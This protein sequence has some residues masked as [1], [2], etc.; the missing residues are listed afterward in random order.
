MSI[1][2][3]L[4]KVQHDGP[5][6]W[7][8]VFTKL[9]IGSIISYMGNSIIA[10]V[11]SLY[12]FDKTDSVLMFALYNFL[13]NGVKVLVPP[14][15]GPYLDRFSRIKAIYWLDFIAAGLYFFLWCSMRFDFFHMYL[16]FGSTIFIGIIDSI[17]EVATGSLY[18]SVVAPENLTRSYSIQNILAT[19]AT[20]AVPVAMVIYNFFGERPIFL[21]SAVIFFIAAVLETTIKF[22]EAHVVEKGDKGFS[23]YEYRQ[24]FRSGLRLLWERKA[25]LCVILS[26]FFFCVLS[27]AEGTL[28]LPFFNRLSKDG[29]WWYIVVSA[30]DASGSFIFDA[31]LYMVKVPAK[32]HYAVVCITTII[33]LAFAGIYLFLPVP[34]IAVS[35]YITGATNTVSGT[36]QDAAVQCSLEEDKKGRY[37]G[38][39]TMTVNIGLLVGGLLAGVMEQWMSIPTIMFMFATIA[40]SV[41]VVLYLCLGRKSIKSLFTIA[42]EAEE[43]SSEAFEVS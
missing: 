23:F 22:T 8:P 21:I 24:D 36:L 16:L 14:L 17:Y 19:M 43:Q 20:V 39:N 11:L 5:R 4:K 29:Y 9:T 13:Y 40:L 7:T 38:I 33:Q 27:G 1:I 25:L 3:K 12:V 34:G 41:F 6:L 10:F 37:C 32:F 35:S 18:P 31:V 42:Q 15:V 28:L 2:Q 30:A 26:L